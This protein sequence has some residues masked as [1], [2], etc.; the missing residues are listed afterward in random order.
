MLLSDRQSVEGAK[1]RR[2]KLH[3]EEKRVREIMESV[4]LSGLIDYIDQQALLLTPR[5]YKE[6]M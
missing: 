1:S 5:R 4:E 6:W 3:W 2:F